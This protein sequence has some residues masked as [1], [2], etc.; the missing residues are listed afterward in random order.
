MSVSK[1]TA[2]ALLGVVV[3]L[4]TASVVLDIIAITLAEAL[5]EQS[6]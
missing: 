6:W 5:E 3:L 4:A 2:A 1:I